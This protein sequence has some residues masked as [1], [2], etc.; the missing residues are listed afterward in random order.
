LVNV[1]ATW[2]GPCAA[3]LE[4]LV[5]MNRM[6]RGRD[7]QLVTLSMD[8]PA[9]K[10]AALRVLKEKHVA[11]TNY[12]VDVEDRDK[13]ADILDNEWPGPL[14]HTL[15]VAPGGKVVYRKNGPIEPLAVKRAIADQL[16][17]TYAS[18]KTAAKK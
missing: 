15:L 1:W 2:C 4:E 5:T 12:I 18:R 3:E 7:F 13:F 6:Y 17:R 14:P 16:G 10:E 9:E 8:D 11:L